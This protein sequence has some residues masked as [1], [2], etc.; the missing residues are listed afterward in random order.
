MLKAHSTHTQNLAKKN[1]GT[2]RPG[3]S[4]SK[5]HDSSEIS[6]KDF[7]SILYMIIDAGR[8][9][10]WEFLS[11]AYDE[12]ATLVETTTLHPQLIEWLTENI[13]HSFAEAFLNNAKDIDAQK[14]NQNHSRVLSLFLDEDPQ[15]V[16]D[17]YGILTGAYQQNIHL[18]LFQSE[19]PNSYK[20]SESMKHISGN[21]ASCLCPLFRLMQVCEKV[22]ND[23]SL[24]EI[25]AVLGCGIIL[26]SVSSTPSE[27]VET[28][29]NIIDEYLKKLDGLSPVTM[30]TISGC[31]FMVCNWFRELICTFCTQPEMSLRKPTIARLNQ[32]ASVEMVISMITE[33]INF[34]PVEFGLATPTKSILSH[35][36]SSSDPKANGAASASGNKNATNGNF[37]V[38]LAKSGY[39]QWNVLNS[40]SN[41]YDVSKIMK[42]SS[43]SK[44]LK[45]NH[46]G[47][48]E[49]QVIQDQIWRGYRRMLSVPSFMYIWLS[50]LGVEN[51]NSEDEDGDTIISAEGLSLLLEELLPFV[52]SSQLVRTFET[53]NQA[54]SW[55]ENIAFGLARHLT[56]VADVNSNSPMVN[57]SYDVQIKLVKLILQILLAF[58]GK[59]NNSGQKCAYVNT[60]LVAEAIIVSGNAVDPDS[61]K[62]YSDIALCVMAFDCIYPLTEWF[63]SNSHAVEIVHLLKLILD[64]APTNLNS[65]SS[66]ES[67][68]KEVEIVKRKLGHIAGKFL[69]AEKV[70]FTNNEI[71]FLLELHINYR[72]TKPHQ[73]LESLIA[74]TLTD[75]S[76]HERNASSYFTSLTGKTAPV[77]LKGII[78]SI[79][80]EMGE[81]PNYDPHDG[82]KGFE[83]LCRM[84]EDVMLKTREMSNYRGV[85]VSSMKA[86]L[87]CVD[88]VLKKVLPYLEKIFL[89]HKERILGAILHLQ[90]ATRT[91]QIIC[92]HSKAIKD[93]ALTRLVP[94]IRRS[95]ESFV[96]RVKTLLKNNNCLSLFDLGPL[97]HRSINGQVV[98][99]QLPLSEEER[100]SNKRGRDSSDSDNQSLEGGENSEEG[101]EE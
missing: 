81:L 15:V 12:L 30:L 78:M 37:G 65:E 18:A 55:I 44:S 3:P 35:Y 73:T 95:L 79:A 34:D 13:A 80:R 28:F 59:P 16:L 90:K 58:M 48:S 14:N 57:A 69:R 11:M 84:F 45:K 47:S 7:V 74:E 24:S 26:P 2:S 97:K 53:P 40:Q 49:N 85:L 89:F 86:G 27:N 61:A 43:G 4:S 92:G 36:S 71:E 54:N 96:I 29:N 98:S 77:F 67:N 51:E 46:R 31:L 70:N 19:Q 68:Y 66:Q 93:L 83:V 99:S 100:P 64:I 20:A 60:K 72:N 39:N 56:M 101:E 41:K 33:K 22:N 17:V 76:N 82:V 91:L 63:E 21:V 62:S 38:S 50:R 75:F 9:R 10:S 8:H 87:A 94:M 52:Y 23:G 88:V 25:D 32:L 1:I 6:F 5:K 42:I